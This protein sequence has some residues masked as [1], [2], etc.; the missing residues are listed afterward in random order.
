MIFQIIWLTLLCIASFIIGYTAGTIH[1][2]K[3]LIMT[4]LPIQHDYL[5]RALQD[6]V[7]RL[8]EKQNG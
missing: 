2:K 7:R 5:V 4:L 6:G 1:F 8:K 3:F